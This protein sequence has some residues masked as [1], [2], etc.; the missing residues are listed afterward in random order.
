MII[1]NSI[2]RFFYT[3]SGGEFKGFVYVHKKMIAKYN[4]TRNANEFLE[5]YLNSTKQFSRR[6]KSDDK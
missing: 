3:F 2:G 1:M 6:L 5:I 4:K